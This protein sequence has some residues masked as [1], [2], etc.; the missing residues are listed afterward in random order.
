MRTQIERAIVDR[1]GK[2]V[3]VVSVHS[4]VFQSAND[5]T[6]IIKALLPSFD[7]IPVVLMTLNG[8]GEPGYF[9]R[10]DLVSFLETIPVKEMAWEPLSVDVDLLKPQSFQDTEV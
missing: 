1:G 4:F 8:K 6:N 7:G 3:A 2:P 10:P 9:G 5:A